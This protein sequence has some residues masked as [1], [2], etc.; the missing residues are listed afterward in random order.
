MLDIN[1]LITQLQEQLES[2]NQELD[3]IRKDILGLEIKRDIRKS[4]IKEIQNQIT[5]LQADQYDKEAQKRLIRKGYIYIGK[6]DKMNPQ[7]IYAECDKDKRH[8][9]LFEYGDGI[10]STYKG[11]CPEC[12]IVIDFTDYKSW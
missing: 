12:D 11:V 1:I 4:Y 7:G 9:L 10:G 2:S 8:L 3:N 5:Q 6:T